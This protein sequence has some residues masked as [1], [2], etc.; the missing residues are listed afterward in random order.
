VHSIG[1]IHQIVSG[2]VQQQRVKQ[3]TIK[4]TLSLLLIPFALGLSRAF[5]QGLNDKSNRGL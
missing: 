5:N 3:T 4:Q 1:S 2:P